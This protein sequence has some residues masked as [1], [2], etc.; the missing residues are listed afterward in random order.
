MTRVAIR[1]CGLGTAAVAL[2]A[3]SALGAK[4]PR[5]AFVSCPI[6]QDTPTVPCWL[7]QYRGETY[8]M[9]IQTD[10]SAEFNPP[11]LGHKVLVEGIVTDKSICGAK[12]IDPI[13]ISIMPEL[14]PECDELRVVREGVDLGF[15]PPRPPGPS[16]GRLAFSYPDPP[17]APRPPFERKTFVITYDFEGM[18]GFRTPQA[19]T[20]ALDYAK[21]VK[22]SRLEV[23]GYRGATKLSDGG[24]LTEHA[25][26]A[27]ER[28]Q[29]IERMFRGA[30]FSGARMITSWRD[31]A[32]EGDPLRRRVEITVIP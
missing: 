18:V 5:I 21:L 6:V 1:R 29:E 32:Q 9:G 2:I 8:Y 10:V 19:L 4:A 15:E 3:A 25:G 31:S 16:G 20:P 24:R 7:T 26:I 27:Q 22:A 14:S 12:V 28:A 11:S 17:A 13:R 30:G 23:V